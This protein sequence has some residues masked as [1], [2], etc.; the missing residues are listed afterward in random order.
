MVVGFKCVGC[1][2]VEYTAGVM[3]PLRAYLPCWDQQVVRLPDLST[4]VR[5]MGATPEE[6]GTD[7]AQTSS[8]Q[9]LPGSGTCSSGWSITTAVDVPASKGTT[10]I[11]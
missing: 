1:D 2:C 11:F 10:I 4:R 3:R 7:A 5:K 6:C 9:D 8:A